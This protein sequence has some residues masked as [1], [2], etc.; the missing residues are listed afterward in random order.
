[1]TLCQ[2]ADSCPRCLAQHLLQE[3]RQNTYTP[4][5][6]TLLFFCNGPNTRST[7]PGLLQLQQTMG[8]SHTPLQPSSR[9]H[10]APTMCPHQ[11]II[12]RAGGW[13]FEHGEPSS[14][15]LHTALRCMLWVCEVFGACAG[16][17]GIPN[18]AQTVWPDGRTSWLAR[19]H[20]AKVRRRSMGTTQATKTRLVQVPVRSHRK[21]CTQLAEHTQDA[22]L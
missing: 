10:G 4:S 15:K 11:A 12:S 6:Q 5:M 3:T 22:P 13:A 2:N 20:P 19:T 18:V 16:R 14:H 9:Q 7:T 21:L 8:G 17:T 1:M